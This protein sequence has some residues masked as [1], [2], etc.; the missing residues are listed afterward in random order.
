M[1][2]GTGALRWKFDTKNSVAGGLAIA[3][4][5]SV[6]FGTYDKKIY[7]LDGRTGAKKWEF[8]TGNTVR[9]S[10]AIGSDGTV[11]IG[12]YDDKVY[13]LD[14]KTGAKKWEFKTEGYAY[15]SPAIG[16][17]DTVY[18]QT[19][20]AHGNWLYAVN[21][22]NGKEK[23]KFLLWGQKGNADGWS[24]WGPDLTM[25]RGGAIC[26]VYKH[27]HKF[28]H[29]CA[30]R[31]DSKG[32]AKSS[33]PMNGRNSQRTFSVS[34]AKP[35]P[36]GIAYNWTAGLDQNSLD[37]FYVGK[38]QAQVLQFFG[39]PLKTQ[40]DFWGYTNMNITDA[41]GNKFTTAWFGFTNGV[42]KQ[43]RFDK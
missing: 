18:I 1:E 41:A 35:L 23:W 4:D 32:L 40:G 25:M 26:F 33:W 21:G 11:Y 43:V 7:A 28:D 9:S 24:S 36:P 15:S 5:G 29:F 30:I 22:S 31:T 37:R 19:S 3:A 38:T 17:D 8:V 10:P 12:S 27:N 34:E 2:A 42:V 13:A 6:Y 20:A 39:K 16:S 14:G